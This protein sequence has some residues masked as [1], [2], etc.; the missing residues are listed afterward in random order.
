MSKIPNRAFAAV[1]AITKWSIT[2][3]RFLTTGAEP[4]GFP[5]V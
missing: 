4:A 3:T 1:M 5:V 2:S